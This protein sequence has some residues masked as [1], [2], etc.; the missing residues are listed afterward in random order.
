VTKQLLKTDLKDR[1]D[2]LIT[3]YKE[4]EKKFYKL[5]KRSADRDKAVTRY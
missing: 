1:Y 5:K 4:L 2:K 3:M